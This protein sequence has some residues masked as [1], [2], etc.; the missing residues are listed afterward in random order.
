VEKAAEKALELVRSLSASVG[1]PQYLDD[2]GASK[3]QIPAL[4]ER[5]MQDNPI[6]TNPRKCTPED[7]TKL[8]L[9]AFRHR[10]A[11]RQSG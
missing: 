9:E 3:D 8:Y 10:N 11:H 7:V 5:A 4:V 1:V 2:V 6:T